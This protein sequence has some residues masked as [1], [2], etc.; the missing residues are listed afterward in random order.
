MRANNTVD[1]SNDD[2]NTTHGNNSGDTE[3]LPTTV[4]P[5]DHEGKLTLSLT[6]VYSKIGLNSL[7]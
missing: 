6:Q 4:S 5:Q 3:S 2:T 1:D 7:S